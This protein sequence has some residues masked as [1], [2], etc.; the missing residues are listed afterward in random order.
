M[1][2]DV[3]M[4]TNNK[5]SRFNHIKLKVDK[6]IDSKGICYQMTT[7]YIY[8]PQPPLALRE[9]EIVNLMFLGD[10]VSIIIL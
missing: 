6:F 10:F 1:V 3:P 4:P 5:L 7:S 9:Y 2:M 8:H